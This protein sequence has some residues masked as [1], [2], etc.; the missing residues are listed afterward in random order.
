MGMPN[1]TEVHRDQ[2]R[3]AQKILAMVELKSLQSAV[4]DG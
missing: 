4:M 2:T 1:V 3:E